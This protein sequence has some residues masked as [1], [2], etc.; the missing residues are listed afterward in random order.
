MIHSFLER[1][2]KRRNEESKTIRA[3]KPGTFTSVLYQESAS[4]VFMKSPAT[5]Q[6]VKQGRKEHGSGPEANCCDFQISRPCL[7]REG[8]LQNM[9]HVLAKQGKKSSHAGLPGR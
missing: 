6:R 5:G 7:G 9:A 1:W 3:S 4:S 2:R 8:K